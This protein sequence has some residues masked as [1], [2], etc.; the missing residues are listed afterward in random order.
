VWAHEYVFKRSQDIPRLNNK[1]KLPLVYTATCSV[2]LFFDPLREGMGEQFLTTGEKGSISTIS[3]TGLVFPQ[4]NAELNFKIFDLLLGQDSLSIG[5]AFFIAKLLRQPKKNDR[6]FII[7]G[8]PLTRLASP[9]LDVELIQ[10]YPDTIAALSLA[11]VEGEVK[12]ASG[13]IASEFDGTVKILAYDSQRS[14]IHTMPGGGKVYYNLPGMVMFKGDAEVKGGKFQASFV[15]PK[16]I[17]YGGNSGRISVYLEGMNQDGA[18][19]KDSLL[20]AG[21]DTT[22]IDSVGPQITVSFDDQENFIDGETVSP[23]S[24]LNI[25]LFDDN[26]INIT[27]EVGHGITLVFDQDFQKETELTERFQYD[28]GSYQRGS[29]VYQLPD[30]SEGDHDLIIKAWDNANNSSVK[31]LNLKVSRQAGL[32]LTEVMNYPNPFSDVTNFYYHLSQDADKVEIKIFTQ[33]GRLIRH[34]P[35]ASAR[36]GHNFS[37]TWNGEDQ[38]GDKVANGVYIYKISAEGT[39][40]GKQKVE[41]AYGKAVVVR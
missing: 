17:S 21:S 18:G 12:N 6:H 28:L 5:E 14:R 20:I 22:V 26:G 37:T 27:G 11:K 24:T 38:V 2:G 13:D 36:V 31:Q 32:Q 30:L 29:L 40:N 23:N 25:Y 4:E 8:D 7:F 34:I 3:A 10:V 41:E 15:V 35:F 19:V 1:R 9:R 33:A 16:D 39:V